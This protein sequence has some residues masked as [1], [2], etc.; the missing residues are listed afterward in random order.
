VSTSRRR[1]S[2]ENLYRYLFPHW[3]YSFH[4]MQI[5]SESEKALVENASIEPL[6][7]KEFFVQFQDH[8]APKLDT[9]EQ[10]LYL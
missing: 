9:Y 1:H 7:L 8:L 10:A 3:V 6:D 2:G 4:N 5:D